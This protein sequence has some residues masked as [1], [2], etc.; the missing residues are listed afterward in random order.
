MN[1]SKLSVENFRNLKPTV[2]DFGPKLNVIFGKNGNGKTNILEAIYYLAKKKSFRKNASF[3]Q[4]LSFDAEKPEIIFQ[5]LLEQEKLKTTISS[6]I[7]QSTY[8]L[9]VNSIESKK[10]PNIPLLFIGPGDAQPFFN[11]TTERR[12]IFDDF[13]SQF[14]SDYKRDLRKLAGALRFRNVLLQKKPYKYIDQIKSSD[15]NLALLMSIISIKRLE[16]TKLVNLYIRSTFKELFLTTADLKIEYNP[17][18]ENYKDTLAIAEEIET[19]LEKQSILGYTL[20]GPHRDD[21]TFYYDHYVASEFCSLGQ[22]KMAYLALLF[23]FLDLCEK[24]KNILPIVLID[25]ISGELDSVRWCNLTE[26]FSKRRQ[27]IIITTANEAFNHSLKQNLGTKNIFVSY[28]EIYT[29]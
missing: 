28:G 7:N 6:R 15:K 25:D 2:I 3:P 4:F 29:T 5:C 23:S 18:L 10:I 26:F 27:Q 1:I 14:D 20:K 12:D 19:D 11:S 17:A 9:F 24:E 13:I 21:F 16:F 8:H 22:L